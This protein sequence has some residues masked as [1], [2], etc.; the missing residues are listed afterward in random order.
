VLVFSSS[1]SYNSGRTAD[2]FLEYLKE[3]VQKDGGFARVDALDPI[4]AKFT[5]AD[6]KKVVLEELKTKV[7]SL[8]G[9]DAKNG[10]MYI[11]MAEKGIEKV[12]GLLLL[13][14]V[15]LLLTVSGPCHVW[16]E[17]VVST[18][19]REGKEQDAGGG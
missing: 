11:K 19:S 10:E 16:H 14:V 13:P 12:G 17:N 8:E 9:D 3:Q 18:A 5:E 6:D 15:S 4:A 2:L 7:A 1:C